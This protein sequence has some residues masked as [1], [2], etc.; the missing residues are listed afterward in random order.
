MAYGDMRDK[1]LELDLSDTKKNSWE[2]DRLWV[3]SIGRYVTPHEALAIETFCVDDE[4]GYVETYDDVTVNL[5]GHPDIGLVPDD[6]QITWVRDRARPVLDKLIDLGIAEI[7]GS[8]AYGLGP[9]T[10]WVVRIDEN[11]LPSI[12]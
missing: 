5:D 12:A 10:A 6:P 2:P 4:I 8:V 1:M 11:K 7:V 9:D 3:A